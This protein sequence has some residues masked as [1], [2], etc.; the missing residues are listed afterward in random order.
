MAL[1]YD[2][3]L[4]RALKRVSS[5]MD[6]SE[7]SFLFDAIAPC[8]AELYEA[9][10]HIEELE[11]RVFADTAYG[12]YL[13]RRTAERGIYRKSA[14]YATRKAYF[15]IDVPIG[16]R[17][18][19][20]E[21]VYTVT[22]K[23][24]EGVFLAK[25]NQTGAIGNRYSGELVNMDFIENLESATL[26]EVVIAGEDEEEDESLRLRYFRSFEKEAFGGNKRDYEEKIGSI[27]GVGVVKV[28]PTWAGGGTVKVRLLDAE[29]NVPS[30]E[31]VQTVQE[32]VDPIETS[33]EGLGIAPIGHKV[34]VEGAEEVEVQITT[35]LIFKGIDWDNIKN[36]VTSVV[37]EYFK[38]LRSK[39][40]EEDIVVRISQIEAR[41]L[42]IEGI[43]DVQGTK[44]NGSSTNLYLT[45]EQVPVL[46]GVTNETE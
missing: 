11:K 5:Q 35:Q 37:E 43:I 33:G 31:L 26:G 32:L 2:A 10:L 7:G 6:T 20:E 3:L 1:T 44:L 40:N 12:E 29:H 13:E 39:W 17:W 30:P 18:A 8:V 21:L 42:E 24:Q 22:E 36:E 25:A 15:N 9:Y 4:Q 38:Q 46:V 45:D 23:V 34:T 41:L 19:K 28:Y 14:T 16:S 27:E